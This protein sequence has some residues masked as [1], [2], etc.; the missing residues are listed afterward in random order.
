M[1]ILVPKSIGASITSAVV[2][3]PSITGFSRLETSPVSPKLDQGLQAM[4]ADPLWMLARQWQFDEFQGNDAGTPLTTSFTVQGLPVT[5]LKPGRDKTLGGFQTLKDDSPPVEALVEFEPALSRHP[6]L[7]AEAGQHALRMASAATLPGLGA[8]LLKSF[9]LTVTA[10]EDPDSD[11]RGLL[12]SVVLSGRSVDAAK[13]AAALRPNLA[14]DGT[15]TA[16]PAALTVPAGEKAA[17]LKLLAAWLA[18]LDQFVLEGKTLNPAW[19]SNRLEYAFSMFAFGR[20]NPVALRA[21]EYTDGHLD[22]HTFIAEAMPTSP[23]VPPPAPLPQYDVATRTPAP[24][25]YPGMPADRYWEF[26][27]ARVNFAA[28]EAAPKD[29][30]RVAL[31]EFALAY[32]NDWFILPV[33][34]PVGALYK[35]GKFMVVDSFGIQSAIKPSQNADGTPW[36]M[37]ELTVKGTAPTPLADVVYLP[38]VVSNALEGPPLELALLVRDEMAN[39]AW[40]I[41]KKVQGTSGDALDRDLEASRLAIRQQVGLDA[42][43]PLL[44]YRLMTHVPANWIPLL[45]V[46]SGVQLADPLVIRL[47]R[48]GMKRFYSVEQVVLDGDPAYADFIDLLRG[49]TSF[50]EELP[51]VNDVAIFVFHPRGLLIRKDEN[52]PVKNDSLLIEE[53]EVPRAGAILQRSFQYART[54]DGR[55]FLWLGRSKTT[56]RGEA[57]SGLRFDVA[58]ARRGV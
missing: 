35:V 45:P 54:A 19:Q 7:N 36:C 53:E 49:Q 22:W 55:A 56:G 37:Y 13:L 4:I 12:W 52:A 26:E 42:D 21:E 2:R 27:D 3:E 50:I 24:V 16:L 38:A 33:E 31:T 8:A 1:K 48:A 14:A 17:A 18:W 40:T 44:V 20:G 32:G 5:G 28:I 29:L 15:L 39:L 46:R 41:E 47:Q 11:V 30:V 34:L 10:P 51:T 43:D 9:A 58:E 6:R 25:R 57:A 23:D